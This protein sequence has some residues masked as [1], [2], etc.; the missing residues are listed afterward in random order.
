M[1]ILASSDWHTSPSFYLPN[2]L[3]KHID[4]CEQ[5]LAGGYRIILPGDIFDALEFGWD[6]YR[7]HPV[8]KRLSQWDNSVIIEGNHDRKNPYLPTKLNVVV[9]NILFRHGHQFD[10]LWGWLPI[11]Y[12][13]VPDF[14]RR[15]Y[16]TPAKKKKGELRDFQLATMQ[17][18]YS[19][20]QFCIKHQYKAIIIGHTHLPTVIRR[21]TFTLANSGDFVD[22]FAWLE[23]DTETN[24]W[25]LKSL[26]Q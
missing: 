10:A 21:E 23:G 18:E 20:Q 13:P 19:A 16:R 11:Y 15:W 2:K 8:I 6:V 17:I 3:A 22:S 9:D 14:I 4:Y 24:Q 7:D 5:R 12:F 26:P 1:K 25:E